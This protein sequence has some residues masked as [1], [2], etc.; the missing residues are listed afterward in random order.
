M[1]VKDQDRNS[2]G[3]ATNDGSHSV[4]AAKLRGDQ[5]VEVSNIHIP[6]QS[7]MMTIF[8]PVSERRAPMNYLTPGEADQSEEYKATMVSRFAVAAEDLD[9]LAALGLTGGD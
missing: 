1:I 9:T 6:V 4:V 2:W 7:E 8:F 5:Y 3:I